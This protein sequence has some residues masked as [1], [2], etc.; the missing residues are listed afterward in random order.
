MMSYQV[1]ELSIDNRNTVVQVVDNFIH[2]IL[3]AI[4]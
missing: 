2:W 4:H 1:V 3:A